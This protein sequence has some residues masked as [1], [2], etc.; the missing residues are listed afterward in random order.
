L[1][2]F[3]AESG[4]A[5]WAEPR[6]LTAFDRPVR[7]L[8]VGASGGIGAALVA[9]LAADPNVERVIGASRRQSGLPAGVEWRRY[10]IDDESTTAGLAHVAP[11][12]VI[13]ATG[14]L[15]IDGAG[16]EKSSTALDAGRLA[17]AFAINAIAPAMLAKYLLPAMPRDR[18]A[19]FACLSARVGSIADNRAGGWY[20]YRASKAAL[21]QLVR[22]LAIEW[23]RRNPASVCVALH[24]GTVDTGLSQPFR[25]GVP[26][27][28]LF[29]PQFA[30]DRLLS[31][32]DGL[33]PAD[34]GGFF[35]WD[36]KRVE[37]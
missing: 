6:R 8:V 21:N 10:D 26:A 19:V 35:A 17:R 31:V 9:A 22:T 2:E 3:G 16:P 20:G 5:P 18:R 27:D 37:Y 1:A 15:H 33:A 7:A 28:K 29:T 34:T 23:A 36:G 32:I 14:A 12:L 13:V 11:E 24:P 30:A 4:A 25:S